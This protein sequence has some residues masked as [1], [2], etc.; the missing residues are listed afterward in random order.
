MRLVS[1]K[2][3]KS[4]AGIR[5]T[6][7]QQPFNRKIGFM[8]SHMAGYADGHQSHGLA[9]PQTGSSSLFA[10]RAEQSL[11]QS[12]NQFADLEVSSSVGGAERT[13]FHFLT[14]GKPFELS[15]HISTAAEVEA[16][17]TVR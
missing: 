12:L 16:A 15:P 9:K 1:L 3:E 5:V 17:P 4:G 7:W 8:L 11:A 14:G 6:G 13:K 10:A 2:L